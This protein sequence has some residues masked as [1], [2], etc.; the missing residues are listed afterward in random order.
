M[1]NQKMM[2]HE[3]SQILYRLDIHKKCN[4][5]LV[6]DKTGDILL[7]VGTEKRTAEKR[8]TS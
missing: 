1:L 8:R 2:Q 5:H 3:K 7:E 4:T 6:P